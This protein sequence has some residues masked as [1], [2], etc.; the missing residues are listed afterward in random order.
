MITNEITVI[1][2][3]E[4][5]KYLAIPCN[6]EFDGYWGYFKGPN[7]PTITTEKNAIWTSRQEPILALP[8][9]LLDFRD[10]VVIKNSP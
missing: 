10:K 1:K 6:I 8:Y 2:N 9:G 5:H 7:K 3:V 4:W